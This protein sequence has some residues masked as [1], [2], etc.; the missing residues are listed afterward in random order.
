MT[1][2]NGQEPAV[3]RAKRRYSS[4]TVQRVELRPE[5]AVLGFCKSNVKSGPI[6]PTS[7]A[8]VL[9]PCASQGS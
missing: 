8:S 1:E 5:E 3:Q 9:G 6:N 7:C 4:P 2:T